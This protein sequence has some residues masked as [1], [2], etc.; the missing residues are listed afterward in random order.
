MKP[1]ELVVGWVEYILKCPLNG[2]GEK[3]KE[4]EKRENKGG[5]GSIPGQ[6]SNA[7]AGQC[8]WPFLDSA[9]GRRKKS[10]CPHGATM[11]VPSC[12]QPATSKQHYASP[13]PLLIIIFSLAQK[14]ARFE[15]AVLKESSLNPP[16]LAL[17]LLLSISLSLSLFFLCLSSG[18]L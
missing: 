1:D 5:L 17:S 7:A 10:P 8:S 18:L 6:C 14:V 13:H 4:K 2:D 3:G 15:F 12:T 16:S 11:S 9:Q